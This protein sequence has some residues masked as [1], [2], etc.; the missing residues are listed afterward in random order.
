MMSQGRTRTSIN[1]STLISDANSIMKCYVNKEAVPIRLRQLAQP[2]FGHLLANRFTGFFNVM[3]HILKRWEGLVARM[4]RMRNIHKDLVRK[5]EWIRPFRKNSCI[6]ESLWTTYR[7]TTSHGIRFF[8]KN[9]YFLPICVYTC[10]KL[11]LLF[12]RNK[13]YIRGNTKVGKK[14][15]Y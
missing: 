2:H 4:G 10:Q 9:V 13:R 11:N 15:Y 5:P 3:C 12:V 1:T 7:Y 8:D 14:S 6:A